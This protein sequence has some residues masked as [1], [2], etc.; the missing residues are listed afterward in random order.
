[1]EHLMSKEHRAQRRWL[2]EQKA[3]LRS[4]RKQVDKLNVRIAVN[5]NGTL[6]ERT[7]RRLDLIQSDLEI[8]SDILQKASER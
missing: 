5:L 3:E 1:V 2:V 8:A 4:I 7:I 6:D